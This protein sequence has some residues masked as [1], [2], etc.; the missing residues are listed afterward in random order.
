VPRTLSPDMLAALSSGIIRPAL[1]AAMTFTSGTVNV[2]SGLGSITW[3]S[4]TWIGLGS[5]LGLSISEDAATVEARGITISLSGLDSST[6]GDCMDEFQ[7][8]LPITLYLGLFASDGSLIADPVT[9]W[10]G[11]MDQPTIDVSGATATISINCE[12]RLIDLN[13]ATD[14]RYTHQDQ[15]IDNP[16]DLG[17]MFVDGIQELTVYW[18]KY[19]LST[20]NI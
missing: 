1:F 14:R 4:A 10:A 2:W 9:T 20:N 11:R 13:I 5:L 12:S 17:F 8:G 19:P 6:L 7:L 3:N 18:G 15:N 16:G